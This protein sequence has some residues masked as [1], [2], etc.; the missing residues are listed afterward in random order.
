M[1]LTSVEGV[2]MSVRTKQPARLAREG[3][4]PGMDLRKSRQIAR[5]YAISIGLW[6]GLS[7]L[8]GWQYRIFDQQL[9]I[10][11]S[12]LDMLLLAESRGFAFALLTPPIFYVVRRYVAG[13]PK[14]YCSSEYVRTGAHIECM[15]HRCHL[16]KVARQG[17]K[18]VGQE[19]CYVYRQLHKERQRQPSPE[20]I[21][22]VSSGDRPFSDSIILIPSDGAPT[23]T[24][25]SPSFGAQ[26]LRS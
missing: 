15:V 12:L 24:L 25:F 13:P 8:T 10:H 26:L 6:C 11:S 16:P 9:N 14:K 5:V 7:L 17:R 4:M 23:R 21:L 22:A 20:V 18:P 19:I 3:I 1:H 2:F